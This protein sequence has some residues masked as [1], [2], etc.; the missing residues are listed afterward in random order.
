MGHVGFGLG[1]SRDQSRVGAGRL[2]T[3]AAREYSS[4]GA[5]LQRYRCRGD[6]ERLLENRATQVVRLAQKRSTTR[7]IAYTPLKFGQDLKRREGSA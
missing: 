5:G 6:A 2:K 3:N 1:T 4:K 7:Q